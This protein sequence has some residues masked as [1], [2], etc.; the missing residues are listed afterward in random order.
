MF[1]FMD[2]DEELSSEVSMQGLKTSF[3]QQLMC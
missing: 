1:M 3:S 2:Y